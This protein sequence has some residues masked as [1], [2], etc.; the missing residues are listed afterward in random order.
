M[1]PV[2]RKMGSMGRRARSPERVVDILR[3]EG[4]IRG[5]THIVDPCIYLLDSF[6]NRAH[7]ESTLQTGA[8][9][10]KAVSLKIYNRW[11]VAFFKR[12]F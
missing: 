6:M 5:I 3:L 4:G 11:G 8:G 9:G 10:C 1:S 2:G 12:R 7:P